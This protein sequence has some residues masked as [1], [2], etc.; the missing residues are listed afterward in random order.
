[1]EN[2]TTD[3]VPSLEETMES[4]KNMSKVD[5]A[6]LVNA[7]IK[8]LGVMKTRIDSLNKAQDNLRKRYYSMYDTVE[9]FLTEF[10]T[11]RATPNSDDLISLAEKLGMEITRKVKVTF[12]IPV[13]LEID[14]PIGADEPD[15]N[16]FE[17]SIDYNGQGEV[18]HEE[19]PIEDFEVED[20]N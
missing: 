2:V 14:L 12:N 6:V 19:S 15:I 11:D 4:L 7:H 8:D 5:I 3:L 9:R 1:M 13:T 20:N 18:D 17:Y 10:L 16:D